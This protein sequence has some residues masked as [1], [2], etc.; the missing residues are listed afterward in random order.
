MTIRDLRDAP[1]ALADFVIDHWKMITKRCASRLDCYFSNGGRSTT[2]H[3][4]HDGMISWDRG[5]GHVVEL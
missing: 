1:E 2:A 5:K 3:T 4:F